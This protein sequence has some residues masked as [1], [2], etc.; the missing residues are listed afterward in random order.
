MVKRYHDWYKLQKD[1][2]GWSEIH[3]DSVVAEKLRP[4]NL[5]INFDFCH[6]SLKNMLMEYEHTVDSNPDFYII[7]D[8]ELS[9]KPLPELFELYRECYSKSTKGIY[10]A[11][12]SYYLEPDCVDPCLIG[13]Y[14]KNIDTVFRKNL[15]YVSQIEEY[16]TVMDYPLVVANREGTMTEGRNYIFVHPN[17]KYFLWK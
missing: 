7:T 4:M 8:I 3:P 13:P 17:I 10:I 16:S 15:S 9:K 11:A 2:Q 14:S 6:Y 12:L 5:S 1:Y